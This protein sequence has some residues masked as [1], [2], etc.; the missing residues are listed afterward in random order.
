[1][2]RRRHDSTTR[3]QPEKTDEE[4]HSKDKTYLE[5]GRSRPYFATVSNSVCLGS[6]NLIMPRR[7]TSR[8]KKEL[9][10]RTSGAERIDLYWYYD[11]GRQRSR[12]RRQ[13]VSVEY[14]SVH[15][16]CW[17]WRGVARE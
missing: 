9:L 13:R 3:Y 4:I 14:S 7:S 11:D 16:C 17:L 5:I 1:M 2:P 10:H 15:S 6:R 8:L 12:Y